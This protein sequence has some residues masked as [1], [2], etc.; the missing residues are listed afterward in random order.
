M[1]QQ[2]STL[3]N[4]ISI[5]FS[6]RFILAVS[7]NDVRNLFQ[8]Y[9]GLINM[10]M[11]I[12]R[13]NKEYDYLAVMWPTE[14]DHQFPVYPV[15]MAVERRALCTDQAISMTDPLHFSAIKA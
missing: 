14:L 15:T 2:A 3:L 6:T 13:Q 7:R 11:V 12:F 8:S 1:N 5:A 9:L 10:W 4:Y